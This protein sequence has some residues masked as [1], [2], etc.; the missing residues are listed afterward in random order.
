DWVPR[1]RVAHV[2]AWRWAE[3]L[4]HLKTMPPRFVA[5]LLNP[6]SLTARAAHAP[7]LRHLED[8]NRQELRTLEM[9]AV[10]G[11]GTVRSVAKLYGSVAN[12][13]S[14]IG[15][16]ANT[17]NALINR[18]VPPTKGIRD[19]VLRVETVFSL[20]FVK[21][22]PAFT[23]GSSDNAFGTPGAGGSF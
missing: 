12:G 14:E 19:R 1:D 6:R 22:F 4:L 9:P 20:G 21:P 5:A 11:T 3:A 7:G 16:T 15:M 8:I 17:L 10:N 2:H 18:A 13:G 23:F